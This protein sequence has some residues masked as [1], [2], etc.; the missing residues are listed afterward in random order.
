MLLE[1]SAGICGDDQVGDA[2][3]ESLVPTLSATMTAMP[4][5]AVSLL[6]GSLGSC[7]HLLIHVLRAKALDPFLVRTTMASRY[8]SPPWGRCFR[9][10]GSA[11]GLLMS[12]LERWFGLLVCRAVA[13]DVLCGGDQYLGHPMLM[14]DLSFWGSWRR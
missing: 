7:C 3:G 2:S 6:E 11:V 4:L 5:G 13:V 12:W 10:H 8:R 14:V 9:S 1:S